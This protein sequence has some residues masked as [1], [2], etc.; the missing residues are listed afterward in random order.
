MPIQGAQRQSPRLRTLA[1]LSLGLW[2]SCQGAP[3]F[4]L[5]H[6]P[7]SLGQGQLPDLSPFDGWRDGPRVSFERDLAEWNPAL[8][9]HRLIPGALQDLKAAL[10]GMDEP[11][12]RAALLLGYSRDEGAAEALALR[13]EARIEGPDQ[14]SDG[15]DVVAAATLAAWPTD[16]R[17]GAR[18]IELSIGARPHPDLEVRV[19]CA[20]SAVARGRTE[21]L[22]FLLRVLRANTPAQREDPPDWTPKSTM[23][24]SKSRAATALS[25]HLGI[26]VTFRPDSSYDDQLAEIARLVSLLGADTSR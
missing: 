3:E 17:F 7:V 11:A 5:E 2:A 14:D 1:I 18:L 4:K 6:T 21:V 10:D 19:E 22:P 8:T 16:E 25:R 13:L 23:A 26:R 15:A 12:M 20:S 9:P 24:W